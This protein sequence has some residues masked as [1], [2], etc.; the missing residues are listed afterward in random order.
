MA[1]WNEIGKELIKEGI[2]VRFPEL[3]P[4]VGEPN[5]WNGE[6][7]KL[8]LVGE[9]NYFE[10][11]YESIS[12]FKK[13]EDW[14]LG[15]KERL[16]PKEKNDSVNNW[17]GSRGHNNIFKSMK[18]VLDETGKKY[19]TYLLQEAAYYNYFLRPASV[20]KSN[21]CFDKDC[22]LIDCQVSYLALRGIIDEIE[23]DIIVF[24]SKFAYSKF[25][26]YYDK[27]KDYYGN[28]IVS[29]VNHFSHAC[30]TQPDGKQKFEN[31]LREYWFVDNAKF[32]RIRKIHRYLRQKFEV[33]KEQECFFD[34]KGSFLSCLYFKVNDI[35]FCCETGVK[36]N[37]NNFWTCFYKTENSNE[38][39]ALEGKGYK[40]TQDFC[41][42]TIIEKIEKLINL[43][44]EEIKETA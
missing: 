22:E 23:P 37:D 33:E 16:I 25:I 13:P 5:Y 28:V 9:S 1:N 2:F 7:K 29:C 26:E 4:A 12:N 31:L 11:K 38:I 43:I 27:E 15:G 18:A 21:K 34:K 36:I 41:N 32:E 10:D 30:W 39:P 42:E 3:I 14:Y 6:H 24:V 40:F 8:L 19:N 35:S 44:I 20:T 17:K